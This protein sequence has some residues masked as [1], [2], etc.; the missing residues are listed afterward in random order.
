MAAA[1]LSLSV[2]KYLTVLRH[3]KSSWVHPGIS[4]HDRPL[5]ERGLRAAPAVA[6]FL[7]ETYFGGAAVPTLL[8][9]P[10]L[11][12][13][14]T[15]KRALTTASFIHSSLKLEASAL[16]SQRELYMAEPEQIISVVRDL[17]EEH[18]H[19]MVVAHNP[20]V[21]DFCNRLLARTSVPRMP[22]CTAVLV[23]LPH[24]HWGLTDWAE[25]QLIGYVT[26][27]NLERR[28]PQRFPLITRGP[29]ELD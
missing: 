6:T 7:H 26:P 25:G 15:A 20:G 12:V 24:E 22:T 23:G 16:R 9:E 29:G 10:T 11:V 13:S 4:D 3:A 5:N 2:M 1:L 18:T 19:V 28:F 8:P 27:R 17:Q 21:H 14:S